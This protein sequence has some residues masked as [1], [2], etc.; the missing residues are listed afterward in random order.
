M[1]AM[2][3][4][5]KMYGA[6]V[7]MAMRS[8]MQYRADF[9]T[10]QKQ[11][12]ALFLMEAVILLLGAAIVAGAVAMALM[13]A[14]FVWFFELKEMQSL[15]WVI[16]HVNFWKLLA[17]AA[18]YLCAMAAI[19]LLTLR[20]LCR[21]PIVQLMREDAEGNR[22][23]RPRRRLR[24]GR[25]AV[26]SVRRMLLSRANGRYVSCLMLSVPVAVAVFVAANTVLSSI[27][28]V[29]PRPEYELRVTQMRENEQGG[30]FTEEDRSAIRALSG[31]RDVELSSVVTARTYENGEWRNDDG[32]GS[33]INRIYVYLSDISRYEA[34]EKWLRDTY[35]GQEYS[36]V[37]EYAEY[38]RTEVAFVGLL[39]LL[40]V[41]LLVLLV[42][43]AMV[44]SARLTGFV[45]AQRG[46]LRRLYGL[47]ASAGTLIRAYSGQA[48]RAAAWGMIL[49]IVPSAALLWV[50]N[51]SEM[52][53]LDLRPGVLAMNLGCAALLA[54]SY[55]LP[56][57]L[58]LKKAM[59]GIRAE[60]R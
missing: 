27:A 45:L 26:A 42:L 17:I 7:K 15:S 34:V 56:V 30:W 5:L 23:R 60:E 54:L 10:S 49:T 1:K 19:L 11:V 33:T 3:F 14:L 46:N 48:E 44:V 31:V 41:F 29:N 6:L 28:V 35:A 4:D 16:F 36:V 52:Y 51:K 20:G 18:A 57:R 39:W 25:S 59:R 37:N 58:A 9:W 32:D 24:A 13:K 21:A 53:F 40:L 38:E 43:E 8:L 12:S 47:G 50:L 22:V 55:I 2:R